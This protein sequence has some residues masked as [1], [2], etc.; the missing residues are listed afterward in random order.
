MTITYTAHENDFLSYQL[1]AASQSERIKKKRRRSRLMLPILLALL[2]CNFS[3]AKAEYSYVGLCG[4]LRNVDYGALGTIVKV[5]NNYFYLKV[6]KYVLNKL[7]FDTLSLLKFENTGFGDRYADYQIGQTEIVFFKK[8]NYVIDNYELIGYGAAFESELPVVGDSIKFRYARG[9]FMSFALSDFINAMDDYNS[10]FNGLSGTSQMPEEQKMKAFADKSKLHQQMIACIAKTEP[11]Y[12]DIPKKGIM[13]NVERNYLYKD[14][15]NKIYVGNLSNDSI[16]LQVEDAEV[17]KEGNY[18]VVNPKSG[19]GRRWLNVYSAK[20]NDKENLLLN[21]LF[22][23]IDLPEPTVYFN[24]SAED[25]ISYRTSRDLIPQAAYYLDKYH[26]DEYLKYTIL[27][28][29]YTITSSNYSETYKV[30]WQYG[31][32][33]LHTRLRSLQNWD[34]ITLSNIYVQYPNNTVK[35]IKN[36]TA[37]VNK[38]Q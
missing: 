9:R 2:L 4:V 11:K 19:W 16:Y 6:E 30:N 33:E 28:Y 7:D 34:K 29:D 12:V 1:F 26:S 27:S 20:G 22:E 24:N 31:T 14:Y 32:V 36:R 38:R 37:V 35:R 8:S 18:F 3:S 10:L 15:D 5:D 23:V 25:T 13:V 17:R 21:Q